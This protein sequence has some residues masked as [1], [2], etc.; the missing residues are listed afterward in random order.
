MILSDANPDDAAGIA[1]IY[2]HAVEHT[3]AIFN[4]ATSDTAGRA[5]WMAERQAQGFPVLVLRDGERV[6]GFGSYGPF[7]PHDGYLHTVE[8]SV[9]VAPD[10]QGQG[11]G[12]RLLTALI[13]RA[14]AERR[15]AMVGGIEAGNAA[16]IALHEALGFAR[17]GL[18]P[19]VAVK[20]GRW[21]DLCLMQR[22]LDGDG[23]EGRG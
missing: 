2:N 17:V 13:D 19:Q 7:R 16:S 14:I 21:L 11:H 23:P 1:A 8:H 6:L 12:R 15:H 22:V 10:A 3:T 9:Y 4:V 5:A 20:F 18:M